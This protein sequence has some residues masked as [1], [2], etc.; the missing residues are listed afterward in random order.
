MHTI[1]M[2]KAALPCADMVPFPLY[3][4]NNL[5]VWRQL[6]NLPLNWKK[7]PEQI[8]QMLILISG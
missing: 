7:E 5:G 6:S 2:D 3:R 4:N 1:A 8:S